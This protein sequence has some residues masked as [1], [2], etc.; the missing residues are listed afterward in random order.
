[1]DSIAG[2]APRQLAGNAVPTAGR[3]RPGCGSIE[4]WQLSRAP[5]WAYSGL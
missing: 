1:M 2:A 4:W 5:A 3:G